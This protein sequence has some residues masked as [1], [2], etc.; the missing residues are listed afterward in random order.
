MNQE[1]AQVPVLKAPQKTKLHNCHPDAG[2]LGQ[3]HASFLAV[4]SESVSSHKL[5]SAVYGFLHNDLDSL[6]PLSVQLLHL[7]FNWT[8]TA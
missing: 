4:H 2:G 5:R 6:T 3:S 1:Q 8:P 7:L